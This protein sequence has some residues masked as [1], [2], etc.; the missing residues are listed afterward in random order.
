MVEPA[1]AMELFPILTVRDA[2]AARR[3]YADLLGG[4]VSFTFPGDD[5]R[6]VY[7]GVDV[8]SSHVGLGVDPDAQAW[9]SPRPVSLWIYTDDC[10]ALTERLREAGVTVAA[11]PADQVWGER[12]ARVL[13]P[14]G[15][16]VVIGQRA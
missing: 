5:G 8:G 4:T 10:D 16:E 13:D 6:P 7:L 2:E 15:N 14:D 1:K 12:I 9:P 3:F 11:E